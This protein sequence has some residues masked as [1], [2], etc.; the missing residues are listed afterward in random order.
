MFSARVVVRLDHDVPLAG[1]PFGALPVFIN[2]VVDGVYVPSIRITVP[3][4]PAV[5]YPLLKVLY[6]FNLV[7]S[8][9]ESFPDGER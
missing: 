9:V 5:A 7:P 1:K 2:P 6:G 8:P 4:A 3:A